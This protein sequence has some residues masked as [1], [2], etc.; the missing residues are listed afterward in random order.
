MERKKL[1]AEQHAENVRKVEQ[2]KNLTAQIKEIAKTLEGKS[3]QTAY[4][5]SVVNLEK[6]NEIYSKERNIAAQA[7]PEQKEMIK[8]FLAGKAEIHE[9]SADMEKPV[10]H[11]KRK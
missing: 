11:K 9:I 1:N 2:V 3:I 7:T 10:E 8:K 4:L 6:K 5:N